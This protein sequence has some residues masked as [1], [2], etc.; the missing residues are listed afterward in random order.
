MRSQS[1]RS[2]SYAGVAEDDATPGGI[3]LWLYSALRRL[4]RHPKDAVALGL[5]VAA[6]GAIIINA[7]FFQVGPHPAPMFVRNTSQATASSNAVRLPRPAPMPRDPIAALLDAPDRVIAVQR[8][9]SDFGYGQIKPDG[10]A[11]P[12]T[13]AAIERFEREHN[14]PVTG[15]ISDQLA[16]RLSALT[17]RPL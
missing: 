17:G 15:Q 11:G 13:K 1:Y 12:E 3:L 16:R 8:A 5:A 14:L 7:L 9:L 10:Q 6:S 2:E 4:L